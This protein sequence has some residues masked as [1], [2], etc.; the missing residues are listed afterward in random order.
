MV[1][2]DLRRKILEQ[3][4]DGLLQVPVDVKGRGIIASKPITSGEFVCVYAGDTI[5]SKEARKKEIDYSKE[6]TT[7]GCYMYYFTHKSAKLWYVQSDTLL[8]IILYV[9]TF[10]TYSVDATRESGRLGRLINHSKTEA[11][12]KTRVIELDGTPYLCLFAARDVMVGEELLF[13][14]G[15][16]RRDVINSLPW[17]K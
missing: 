3:W 5:S 16:R 2:E 15:E 7:R 9:R 10:L 14:Y 12:L 11:N 6:E 17:L 1:D 13:D 4:E 8:C